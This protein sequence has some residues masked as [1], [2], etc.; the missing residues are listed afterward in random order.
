MLA[1]ERIGRRGGRTLVELGQGGGVAELHV[2]A[3]NRHGSGQGPGRAGQ[4][5]EPPHDGV[6]R[7]PRAKVGEKARAI[8]GGLRVRVGQRRHER[9]A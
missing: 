1:S 3:E 6:G 2:G 9:P 7:R 4:P 8:A 5:T